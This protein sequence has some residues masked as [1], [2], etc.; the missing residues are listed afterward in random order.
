MALVFDRCDDKKLRMAMVFNKNKSIV[1]KTLAMAKSPQEKAAILTMTIVNNPGR[2]LNTVL[3]IEKLDPDYY[4]LDFLLLREIN[5]LEDWILTPSLTLSKPTLSPNKEWRSGP[6]DY[7][8][9]NYEKDRAYLKQVI[10]YAHRLMAQRNNSR[11]SK[12][13]PCRIS[14]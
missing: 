8:Q 5:K 4:A 2:T 6:E 13:R 10:I 12:L 11:A 3:E 9:K 14:D 1:D 7:L